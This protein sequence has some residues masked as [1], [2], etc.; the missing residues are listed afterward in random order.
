MLVCQPTFKCPLLQ[1]VPAVNFASDPHV[2][3]LQLLDRKAF[4]NIVE[5]LWSNPEDCLPC[6]SW[7]RG[8]QERR[9]QSQHSDSNSWGQDAVSAIAAMDGKKEAT[10]RA[11]APPQQKQQERTAKRRLTFKVLGV[12]E[13]GSTELLAARSHST[14]GS[15][16]AVDEL[17]GVEEAAKPMTREDERELA[18][19]QERGT[20]QQQWEDPFV[21]DFTEDV[22]DYAKA[23]GYAPPG[24]YVW[25]AFAIEAWRGRLPPAKTVERGWRR[26]GDSSSALRQ[27]L[28]LLWQQYCTAEELSP[29]ACDM[30]RA[31]DRDFGGNQDA[32][33]GFG[34]D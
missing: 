21:D 3:R 25:R 34:A 4:M 13:E 33:P 32:R 19:E 30:L 2:A 8:R 18:R 20:E 24:S 28:V 26:A 22:L 7:L 27:V 12:P 31:F 6:E 16:P 23:K 1:N 11:G 15:A 17:L 5:S 10:K 9:R 29:E 14:Q